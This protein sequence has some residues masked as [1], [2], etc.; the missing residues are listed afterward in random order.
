[1]CEND[2]RR[3]VSVTHWGF[4]DYGEMGFRRMSVLKATHVAE[5]VD[6]VEKV[7]VGGALL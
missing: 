4:V 3:V 6:G 2:T 5:E 1:M 7:L